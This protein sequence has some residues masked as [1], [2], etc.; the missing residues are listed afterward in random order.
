MVYYAGGCSPERLEQGRA[1]FSDPAHA[2]LGTKDE[3]SRM[4]STV[5]DC[6]GLRL[7]ESAAVTRFLQQMAQAK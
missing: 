5:N 7:R 2:P 4:E 3:F 6:V 1:F